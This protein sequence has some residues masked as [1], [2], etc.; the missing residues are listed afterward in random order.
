MAGALESTPHTPVLSVTVLPG[1]RKQPRW[2]CLSGSLSINQSIE[3]RRES[4]WIVYPLLLKINV[5]WPKTY[6]YIHIYIYRNMILLSFQSAAAPTLFKET[7]IK[8]HVDFLIF[9]LLP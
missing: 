4:E 8:I 2:N 6:I 5:S 9:H 1:D 3:M 7:S